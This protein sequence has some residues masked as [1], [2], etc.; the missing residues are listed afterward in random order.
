MY[1]CPPNASLV[2]ADV[3]LGLEVGFT[4]I[5]TATLDPC[6]NDSA[7]GYALRGVPRDSYF[8]ISK[9]PSGLT[10]VQA[11]EALEYALSMLGLPS[12]DLMLIH[13]PNAAPN[14]SLTESLQQ[15]WAALEAFHKAVNAHHNL[16]LRV[17]YRIFS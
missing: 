13:H 3:K 1:S 17:V 14:M 9:I 2:V 16:P 11:G 15:Q 6:Y 12:V 4:S 7:V 5:D 8:L 10:G